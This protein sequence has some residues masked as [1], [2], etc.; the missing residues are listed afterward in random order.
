MKEHSYTGVRKHKSNPPPS[1][2]D[3]AWL[4]HCTLVWAA[5][6]PDTH[7]VA[8]TALKWVNMKGCNP[9]TVHKLLRL[10]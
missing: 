5:D 6:S 8:T 3:R 10:Y 1:M 7:G 4:H 9:I 2:K